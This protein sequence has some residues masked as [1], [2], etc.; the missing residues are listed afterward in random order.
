MAMTS[1]PE[2][3][4][5]GA[6][7]YTLSS[8]DLSET[9]VQSQA[10]FSSTNPV[11][12][13]APCLQDG[14]YLLHICSPTPLADSNFV[15]D[16]VDPM[17]IYQSQY[18]EVSGCYGLDVVLSL[19]TD[20]APPPPVDTCSGE[21]LRWSAMA[22]YLTMPPVFNPDT[23]NWT[24][25]D[26]AGMLLDQ[27]DFITTDLNPSISDSICAANPLTCYFLNIQCNDQ[28]WGAAYMEIDANMLNVVHENVWINVTSPQTELDFL[29]DPNSCPNRVDEQS[30][31]DVKVFP[32]P[33]DEHVQIQYRSMG[34][35]SIE[36]IAS[37]GRCVRT[38]Q[39]MMSGN[40]ILNLEKIPAGV[41]AV[42]VM[43]GAKTTV[44]MMIKN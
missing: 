16:V 38:W 36:L 22:T 31:D 35:Y 17:I 1:V 44:K 33:A 12:E 30:L 13:L 26:V 11:V 4:G 9:I 42:R 14:C 25:T 15:V 5:T 43:E 23:L 27:G 34:E 28:I 24:I 20:C 18:F 10:G 37:D 40:V 19:N 32:N 41:Y 2:L 29:M 39:H 3:G 8:L 6:V 7:S 21:R